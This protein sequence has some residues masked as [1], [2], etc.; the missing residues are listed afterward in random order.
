MIIY[1]STEK[2]NNCQREIQNTKALQ[3]GWTLISIQF[4]LT[5]SEEIYG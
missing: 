2:I 4:Y 5:N 1:Q 3:N